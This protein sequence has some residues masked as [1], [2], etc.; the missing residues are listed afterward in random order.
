MTQESEY[1]TE[2]SS[3]SIIFRIVLATIVISAFIGVLLT[4]S[5]N[6]IVP[7]ISHYR[8]S[9]LEYWQG[10]LAIF[11]YNIVSLSS[12]RSILQILNHGETVIETSG[13]ACE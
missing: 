7:Q 13:C 1:P 10:M 9:P 4:F 11:V 6:Q 3:L 5:W 8:I 12:I 2:P